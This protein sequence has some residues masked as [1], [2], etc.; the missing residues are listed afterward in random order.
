M[1]N[2]KTWKKR[3]GKAAKAGSA[4]LPEWYV[5]ALRNNASPETLVKLMYEQCATLPEAAL[6]SEAQLRQHVRMMVAS[7]MATMDESENG[8]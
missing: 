5:A 4:I 1:P 8:Q 3:V 7:Y 2:E 6:L